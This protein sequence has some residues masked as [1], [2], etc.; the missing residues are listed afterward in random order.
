MLDYIEKRNADF[1]KQCRR[2]MQLTPMGQPIIMSEILERAIAAQPPEY[3]LS[4]DYALRRL[5]RMRASHV[6]SARRS[7]TALWD[8]LNEK[9]ARRQK[10]SGISDRQALIDELRE[11]APSSFHITHAYATRLFQRLRHQNKKKKQCPPSP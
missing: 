7:N 9:V 4:F 5:R 11:G 2:Q 1:M 8:E 3:Y 6:R 10:R